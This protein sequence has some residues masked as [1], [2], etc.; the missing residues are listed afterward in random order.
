MN[1]VGGELAGIV[2]LRKRNRELRFTSFFAERPKGAFFDV[3][4]IRY[5]S[6]KRG[7][8]ASSHVL[9]E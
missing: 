2:A 1:S 9:L 3:N 6:K 5:M 7:F 4:T 8:A